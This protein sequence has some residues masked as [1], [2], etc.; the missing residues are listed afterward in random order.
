MNRKKITDIAG[1]L[2][3]VTCIIT[4]M[5][6]HRDVHHI[7]EY[8]RVALWA[9]H[10]A[11]G[12]LVLA[13]IAVHCLQHKAWFRNYRKI[14]VDKKRVS[15]M[16]LCV[17]VLVGASGIVLMLGSRSEEVSVFHYILGII[18]TLLALGHV[19]KC[20]KLFRMTGKSK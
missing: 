19:I 2:C 8:H 3:V 13:M 16:I 9:V 20:W 10:E 6:L 12:V 14:P 1:M 5:I 11:A 18:F 7:Y 17:A 4:G 15:T